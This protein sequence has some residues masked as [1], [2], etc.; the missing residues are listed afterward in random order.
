MAE[1]IHLASARE[2][3]IEKTFEC[4]QCFRW[5]ADESGVYRGIAFGYPARVWTENGEVYL[6]SDAPEALWREYFDLDRDY[7]GISAGFHG[8]EYL[9]SCIAYGQ[10]IRILRQEPWETLCSFII[11]QCNNISRIKGIVE[12]LCESFGEPVEFE[13]AVYYAFP[14]AQR[15]AALEPGALDVLRCGYRA[16]YI[17]SAAQAVAD[18]SLDLEALISCDCVSAR[19]RLM[20]EQGIGPKVANCVVLF[21]LYHLEAFPID[22]WIRR[23]LKENFPKD[24]DPAVLGE[25]AGLAQQ[26][27]F[28][29]ARSHGK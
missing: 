19:A 11:S 6:C 9:D 23:A 7:A 4:G 17:M 20:R 2:L 18:G 15:I 13:G 28:Y 12:R 22:V 29:Y 1:T 3:D 10:G 25:Y 26:Y 14:S 8:G 16:P 5:N 21:G 27:I 24:F